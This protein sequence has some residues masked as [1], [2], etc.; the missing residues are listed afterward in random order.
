MTN[1]QRQRSLD[2]KKWIESERVGGDLSGVMSHCAYCEKSFLA[3]QSD[4]ATSYCGATQQERENECLCA[5]AFNRM[6]RR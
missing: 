6:K 5:K 3:F 4:G 1:K 2:K